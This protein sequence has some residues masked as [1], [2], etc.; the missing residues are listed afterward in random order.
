[1]T[2]GRVLY[3]IPHSSLPMAS[4][5][6]IRKSSLM[7]ELAA[8]RLAR[9]AVQLVYAATLPFIVL[10]VRAGLVPVAGWAG[11]IIGPLLLGVLLAGRR[12]ASPATAETF[13]A[14]A[15]GSPQNLKH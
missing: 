5:D 9:V 1:M 6:T 15:Q 12:R 14:A 3:L 13:G 7:R 4:G 8:P 11:M 2:A 10:Y